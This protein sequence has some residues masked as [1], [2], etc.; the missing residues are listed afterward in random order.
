[1]G[2]PKWY[3]GRFFLGHSYFPSVSNDF[4]EKKRD[5]KSVMDCPFKVGKRWQKLA[6]LFEGPTEG[7]EKLSSLAFLTITKNNKFQYVQD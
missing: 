3:R 6:S 4:S 1:M 2:P 7:V 5:L